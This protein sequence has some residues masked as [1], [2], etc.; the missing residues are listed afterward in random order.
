[1]VGSVKSQNKHVNLSTETR[2]VTAPFPREGGHGLAFWRCL[3]F[4]SIGCNVMNAEL[5]FM[6]LH[7]FFAQYSFPSF[8][9]FYFFILIFLFWYRKLW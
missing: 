3:E 9:F 7:T 4:G 5:V 6:R 2:C 1:M 8:L